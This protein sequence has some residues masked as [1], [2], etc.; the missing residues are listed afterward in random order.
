MQDRS[1]TSSNIP[2]SG[3]AP[4]RR[5]RSMNFVRKRG[6]DVFFGKAT[7]PIYGCSP[8][9]ANGPKAQPAPSC[10][11]PEGKCG[12]SETCRRALLRSGA[13][14]AVAF[15]GHERR[16][17]AASTSYRRQFEPMRSLGFGALDALVE[18]ISICSAAK[19][20]VTGFG[21]FATN[22]LCCRFRVFPRIQRWFI[23][24]VC[25]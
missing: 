19:Q 6:S 23:L 12:R 25:V 2:R 15:C 20:V 24:I 13:A 17:G 1:A 3:T 16:R 18:M 11:I 4:A 5:R 10:P 8:F 9:R 14:I 21:I 7:I 22:D